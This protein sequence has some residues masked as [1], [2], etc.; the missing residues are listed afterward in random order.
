MKIAISLSGKIKENN[1]NMIGPAPSLISKVG[2]KFRWQL[3]L[4][5]PEDSDLPL[6][7]RIS[8]W[9]LIPKDIFLSIDVNP[10]EL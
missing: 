9:E 1:W 5:G 6:P 8:L 4:H 10:V 7:D 2:K 3:L